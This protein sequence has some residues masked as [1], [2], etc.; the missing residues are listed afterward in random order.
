[1]VFSVKICLQARHFAAGRTRDPYAAFYLEKTGFEGRAKARPY[2]VH[3]ELSQRRHEDLRGL[4]CGL[5]AA[6]K[7]R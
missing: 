1:M 2:T 5:V 6:Y 4:L 7:F 3:V